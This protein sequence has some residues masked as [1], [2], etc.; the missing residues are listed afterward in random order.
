MKILVVDD[1]EDARI[2]LKMTLES[3]GY[4]VQDAQ[5]GVEALK[6]ARESPPDMIIS[7]ILMPEM[8]GYRLCR[9]IKQNKK[10]RKIP[11]IFYSSTF[12]SSKDEKYAEAL[13]AS[14]FIIKP[15]EPARFL[16]II[17]NLIA[18]HKKSRLHVPRMPLEDDIELAREH[19]QLVSNKLDQK[20]KDIGKMEREISEKDARL[21]ASE[22]KYRKLLESASDAIFIV[23]SQSGFIIDANKEAEK[24]IGK[25]I[26]SIKGLHHTKLYAE[27]DCNKYR[28][29]LHIKPKS[30]H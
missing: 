29:L 18:D 10:L 11:F 6:I 9:E 20:I 25:P 5:N 22:K 27:Q 28:K 16:E 21:R 24:L 13:G 17:R 7:D 30:S 26:N 8:D 2:I 19:E 1:I 12:T 14:R 3:A 4:T 15:V 23:D